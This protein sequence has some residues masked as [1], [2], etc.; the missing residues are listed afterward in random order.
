MLQSAIFAD[1]DRLAQMY[2][3]T[4]ACLRLSLDGQA[5]KLMSIFQKSEDQ[6]MSLPPPAPTLIHEEY[7]V[8]C[9]SDILRLLRQRDMVASSAE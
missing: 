3:C 8:F 9:K 4:N 5:N 1:K 6:S 2:V 7:T